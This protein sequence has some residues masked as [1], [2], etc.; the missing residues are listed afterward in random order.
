MAT[1]RHVDEAIR[2]FNVATMNAIQ[3]GAE[4]G[5]HGHFAD[6]VNKVQDTI[7]KRFSKGSTLRE[8]KIKE[9]LCRSGFEE[10]AVDRAIYQLVAKGVLAYAERRSKLTRVRD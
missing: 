8:S 7:R 6:Q 2:L 4:S 10:V 9:E 1:E 5:Q 3:C